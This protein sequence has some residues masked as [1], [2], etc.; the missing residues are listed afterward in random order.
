M[1]IS[2]IQ[3]PALFS[4]DNKHNVDNFCTFLDALLLFTQTTVDILDID[5]QFMEM[6][7]K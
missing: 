3:C 7:M 1:Y 5:I 4:V 2:T 6:R